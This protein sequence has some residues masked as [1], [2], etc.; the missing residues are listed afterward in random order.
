VSHGVRVRD[1][2][3]TRIQD[4]LRRQNVFLHGTTAPVAARTEES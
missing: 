4:E 1:V 2:D 3:V